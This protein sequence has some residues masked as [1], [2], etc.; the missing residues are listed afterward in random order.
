MAVTYQFKTQPYEHQSDALSKGAEA[1]FFAY[2]MDMGTGKSK[3]L[4]DNVGLLV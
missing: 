3:V 1:P 4:L 2:F